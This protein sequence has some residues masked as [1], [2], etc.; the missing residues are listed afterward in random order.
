MPYRIATSATP[1][2]EDQFRPL[3]QRDRSGIALCLSGG[4]FRAALFPLG[5]LRR[6]NGLA[7]LSQITSVSGVSGGSVIAAFLA[8][9][10]PWP[11]EPLPEAEWDSRIALP[12]RAFAARNLGTL[13]VALG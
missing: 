13:P 6:L 5:A 11:S 12:F 4:G 2:A 3:P 10:L 1:H 9:R 7:L 8:D